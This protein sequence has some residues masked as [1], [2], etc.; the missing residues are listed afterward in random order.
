MIGLF[1]G[2]GA[3]PS[4][5][6]ESS[7]APAVTSASATDSGQASSTEPSGSVK[8]INFLTI[9]N[10]DSNGAKIVKDLTDKYNGNAPKVDVQ[11]DVV[12]QQ[13]LDQKLSVL[14]ASN[15]FPEMFSCAVAGEVQTYSQKGMLL[16][17]D[18]TLSDLGI[19]DVISANSRN[20]LLALTGTSTLYVLPTEYDIE[21]VW[22]N[23]QIF[24]DNGFTV[25]ATLDDMMAICDKCMSLGIQPFA[26]AGK[27]RWPISRL[28]G[29][30]INRKL[31]VEALVQA[32]QGKIRFDEPGFVEGLT[33]VSDMGKKEY[34]GKGVTTIDYN[35]ALSVFLSGKSAM[36]YDGSWFT[37]ELNDPS[38]NKI[39]ENV[40]F[41]GFPTVPGGV[42]KQND[43][44]QSYGTYYC[45]SSDKYDAAVGDWLKYVL[46]NYGNYTLDTEGK[47]T[48][49]PITGDHQ[50]PYY[51]D[52]V[53]QLIKDAGD[54]GVWPEYCLTQKSNDLLLNDMQLLSIGQIAPDKMAKEVAD[55][56]AADFNK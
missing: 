30:Y 42:G 24:Q 28:A 2:C 39:G 21:G 31:G 25:P 14:A 33:M 10:T 19:S 3:Q 46:T 34:F 32:N 36:Y 45:L 27:E 52:M 49:Y 51:T 44:V 41:F 37:E 6:Q 9:W 43:Y 26:L 50:I 40:G 48:P 11:F 29:N 23:K 12:Q 56:V 38:L 53:E 16:D 47:L 15:D 55:S 18:K 17:I 8:T 5:T 7:S 13:A 54:G 1:S 4:A 20:G 22:Y 35:T